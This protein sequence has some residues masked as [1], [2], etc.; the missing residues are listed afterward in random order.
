M[1]PTWHRRIRQFAVLLSCTFTTAAIAQTTSVTPK[2]TD[3]HADHSHADP[4]HLLHPL[5]VESPLPENEARLEFTHASLTDGEGHESTLT[6]TLEL[7]PV[8]WF[9][10]ELAAPFTHLDPEEGG[11]ETRLG[12][13]STG[14]KFANFAFEEY[15]VLLAGGLELGLP[16]GNEERGIGNDHV[17]EFEPWTG[18]GYKHDHHELI[19]RVGVGIPTNQGSDPEADVEIEWGVSWLYH[20]IEHRLATLLEVDGT[21]IIGKEED[22]YNSVA[23]TPGVR[24]HPFDN[25]DVS[26]G[27]GIR[28]PV[29]DD[30]DS[31]VQGIVTLFFHF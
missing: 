3:H 20:L 17:L 2:Q 15:G 5:V 8:R 27:A 6:G 1:L 18:I 16:T 9:S 29:T 30:R 23:I 7:A 10:V 25:P 28:L 26:F 31:H 13:I 4:L 12:N 14:F 21:N 22:G 19:A 11:S 24:I